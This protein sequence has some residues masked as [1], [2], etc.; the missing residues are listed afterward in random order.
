MEAIVMSLSSDERP[1]AT[2]AEG[3]LVEMLNIAEQLLGSRD[4]AGGLSLFGA[5]CQLSC[6]SCYRREWRFKAGGCAGISFLVANMPLGWVNTH[7]VPL[8]KVLHL[9]QT[10]FH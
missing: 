1:I 3:L 6:V 2:V 8:A 9:Q 7:L 5:V 4:V 10:G